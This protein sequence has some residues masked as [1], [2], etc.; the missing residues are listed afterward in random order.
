MPASSSGTATTETDTIPLSF[1]AS[2][3]PVGLYAGTITVAE[4]GVPATAQTIAVTLTVAAPPPAAAAI[5]LS[6]ASLAASVERGKDASAASFTVRNTGGGTLSYTVSDSAAWLAVSPTSGTSTGESDTIGVTFS[7]AS[8][9]AGSHSATITV[10][11]GSGVAAQTV[12]VSLTVTEPAAAIGLSTA[13]LAASVERGKDAAAASFTVRNTG[14]GTLSYTVS[15]SAAWLAVSPTSG[16][17]TGESDTIGVTFSTASLA[18]GSHS[19]TITV[20]GGSGV[21]AQTVAV[22]LTVTEPAAAIG[23]STA[24]LAASVERGKDASAAS[25]TVRNTGGGTLSYTVSDSAAWLAVSPTS[26]TSTGESDTIGVT[27]STASL[28]A[29]SHSATI[30]VGGGSGVAAQTVAV[31]LTVTE[32]AAAISATPTTLTVTTEKGKNAP[33]TSFTVRNTGSGRLS[34]LSTFSHDWIVLSNSSGT[35]RS[36]TDTVGVSFATSNLPVG[37]Y[38]GTITVIHSGTPSTEVTITVSLTVTE[39]AAAIGLSTASLAASV[40]RGKD[41]SA[42]SFTVRNTG[43][44]TLS[45]TVSDSAAWLAVSPTSGTST[46]ESDTIGVTFSTASLAAGSHSAT[47]TVGGGSGVAAQTVAVSLTVTEPAAAIG[48]STA[49][50]AASVERGKDA[51]AASFTV[52]N[53]GGGTLSY[54]VSDSAAWLAVS[55][56]SGTSTGESDTIGVTFSTASLAAGSHSATITVGGGSGVAAQTVA[57]SLTVTEPAA[58]IGLSTASLAASVERGK[59]ASAASFTVR[60]TGGGTLSYTVSD[61]AAWLAVSPT[62]GTSTGESDTIGVTFSTASLAAGSHSATITVGGGSGVAAQTI[63]VSLTVTEPAAAIGLSTASLAASVERGKDAS[64]ASFTVRNTGGGTLS[65]TVSDS[66]AWLAV[67]PTSGTSTGESDT[68]GV[69]FST[70]SLAAGSHSA[71]ITVG[72]GSGVA[73]Q[74]VAVSLTVTEPAAAIGLSTASLAASVER[75][76]DAA[77]ASFTVRNTGGGTLS[78]TVSDSAA[79]LAVSPTSGTSTGESDTIGV[80]FSTA[81]LA[82]GSHSATITVGGGSGVAAKTIAVFV[83]VVEAPPALEVSVTSL[84]AAAS[85][86][87]SPSSQSFTI[88]NAGGGTLAYSVVSDQTWVTVSPASGTSTGESDT[89]GVTFSTASLAAGSHTAALTVSASGLS[90][91]TIPISLSL[92]TEGAPLDLDG[93]AMSD[94]L[95]RH[96][97]GTVSGWLMNGQTVQSSVSPAGMNSQWALVGA[98]D[99]DGDSRSFDLLWMNTSSGGVMV[100]LNNGAVQ[101]SVGNIGSVKLDWQVAGVADFDGDA[102]SD[103]LWI[104]PASGT[105]EL[106]LLDRFAVK[107]AETLG[108]AGAGWNVAATV[109]FDG[110]GQVDVL[111]QHVTSPQLVVWHLDRGAVRQSSTLGFQTGWKVAAAGDFNGDGRADLAAVAPML[112]LVWILTGN[113]AGFDATALMSWITPSTVIMTTGDLARDGGRDLLLYERTTGSVS[114]LLVK[115]GGIERPAPVGS[116]GPGWTP[117][118][119]TGSAK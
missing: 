34:Y 17:S 12:A 50:L 41:A 76:K 4:S 83:T 42:A 97:D 60:N 5:G 108:S 52:R 48:L 71:T 2:N 87:Q 24:S 72:G 111:F 7:T 49:S 28:A 20:G 74:T 119:A 63:T 46:G 54:T 96:S 14:G 79:W 116:V 98:G 25:F 64:A 112:G 26:G 105:L 88:R 58:A 109:D 53:T 93:N 21:A 57:V 86:G 68:I 95:F 13:S 94:L 85:P 31:S 32:P 70:A 117:V 59:D 78:Y 30:T 29:G 9:A 65:Y 104:D 67:S 16:T 27:F 66:A 81:S 102:R 51:A 44:G 92:A 106:W 77:A 118:G 80:T 47:I 69:T 107:S 113:G 33:S 56:T 100:T 37:T 40:E 10:G 62:S 110:D 36:E 90:P 75:G 1:A 55:P 61:S 18:A 3:L 35:V 45:Y 39:P 38:N 6:T 84:D 19:A 23:L 22:S 8:L 101:K 103:V 115:G 11:G 91:K 43:G 15:D 73:A 89:I 82:A 99:F 114:L